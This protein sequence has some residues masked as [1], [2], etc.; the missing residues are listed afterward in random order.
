MQVVNN[1]SLSYENFLF[2]SDYPVVDNTHILPHRAVGPG[3]CLGWHC[4]SPW[5]MWPRPS[6]RKCSAEG[7]APLGIAGDGGAL[8]AGDGGAIGLDLH[9]CQNLKCSLKK[10]FVQH[11]GILKCHMAVYPLVC[12]MLKASKCNC[13]HGNRQRILRCF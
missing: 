12:C 6:S 8:E 2:S 4:L 9:H 5:Q 1:T 13:L 10:P 3:W 7:V 11:I